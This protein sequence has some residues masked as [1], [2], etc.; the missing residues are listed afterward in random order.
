MLINLI[1]VLIIVGAALY[2][3]QYIPMDETFK[4]VVRV[5]IIIAVIIY[6]LLNVAAPLLQSR[7]L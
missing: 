7:G 4:V 5:L 1:I 2:L 3:L 6:V